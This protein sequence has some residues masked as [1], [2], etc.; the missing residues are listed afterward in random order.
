MA[1]RRNPTRLNLLTVRQVQ[2]ADDGDHNDGG[3]LLLRVR[4]ASVSWVLR[5]TSPNGKRR[6]MGLGICDRNNPAI[7]GKRLTDA[8]ELAHEQRALLQRSVDPIDFRDATRAALKAAATEKKT[9]AVREGLTLARAARQYHERAVEPVRR[10]KHAALWIAS[11]ENHMPETLWHRPISAITAPELLDCIA[12]L[13]LKMPETAKRIR[14]RL[15]ATKFGSLTSWRCVMKAEPDRKYTAE[16][17]ETAVRQVLDGGR[18]MPRVARSL[19][20][21]GAAMR[22]R[23]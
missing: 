23:G 22:R 20:A 15:D 7:A 4:G 17:C 3:G 1:V 14:Q 11:L 18:S 10:L 16:F 6:E 21:A 19:A 9:E 12:G 5:F 2:T 8:R 13:Q